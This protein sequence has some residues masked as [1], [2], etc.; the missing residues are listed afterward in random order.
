MHISP[1]RS[2]WMVQKQL[3]FLPSKIR[4]SFTE[5]KET[6][7]SARSEGSLVSSVLISIPSLTHCPEVG[8]PQTRKSILNMQACP[9]Y[10]AKMV[11]RGAHERQAQHVRREVP[12]RRQSRR[13]GGRVPLAWVLS[14]AGAVELGKWALGQVSP[15]MFMRKK[16]GEM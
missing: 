1:Y 14:P 3:L 15:E 5:S 4:T 16:E 13:Q 8:A 7:F 10:R 6:S 9:N 2:F 12:R 11:S